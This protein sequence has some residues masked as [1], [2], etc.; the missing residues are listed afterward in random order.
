VQKGGSFKAK[1]NIYPGPE[2]CHPRVGDTKPEGGCLPLETMKEAATTLG[3][4]HTS[5]DPK[6][7]LEEVAKKVDVDPK[8]Q[9]SLLEALPF[10]EEKRK[11]LS[12]LWLRPA[13]PSSWKKDPDMWLDSTNI[14]DVMKQY[15]EAREDFRFLGP[16][17][18][19]F[20]A[21]D[22]YDTKDNKEKKCLIGE[23]CALDLEKEIVKG[24]V[25]IG[26][27][28]NLDPHYKDGSHWV[29]LY[30][31]IT[32]KRCYYFDS[33]GLKPPK[34]IY[35][36]MQWLS[37]QEPSIELGWNGRKF[38]FSNSECG[39]YSMYFIDRMISGEP[40]L[41]FCR[42]APPDSFMLDMRDWIYST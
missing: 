4:E 11:E 31:H 12:R 17:P 38:Q 8:H 10:S 35:N 22:P 19:D 36:F 26:I 13:Q 5:L 32:K 14:R 24:K 42:R 34:Q 40:F 7:L 41:H 16:Y 1:K 27:I 28:F 25:H 37:L 20:A 39:M 30:I 2:Q 18:I 33:Y 23:M 3:I 15:E 6:E 9:R 21:Q 29:G